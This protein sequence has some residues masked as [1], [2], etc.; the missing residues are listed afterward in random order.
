MLRNKHSL[1]LCTSSVRKK[2]CGTFKRYFVHLVK[3]LLQ[4]RN[5]MRYL[6]LQSVARHP[7]HGEGFI[8]LVRVFIIDTLFGLYS[9]LRVVRS[10]DICQSYCQEQIES[11]IIFDTSLGSGCYAAPALSVLPTRGKIF[12]DIFSGDFSLVVEVPLIHI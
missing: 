12:K 9:I 5:Q 8:L 10:C 2:N 4:E 6:I 11:Q 1:I 7:G 3:V